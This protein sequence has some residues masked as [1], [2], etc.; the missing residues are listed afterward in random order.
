MAG[1]G[2]YAA[3]WAQSYSGGSGCA[4]NGNLAEIEGNID[5]YVKTGA[6]WIYVN[7]P[8]PAPGQSTATSAASIAY[9]V[10]GMN[11][12]YS[13]IHSKHPGVMFGLTLGDDGG[14]PL[15]LAMLKAGLLEDFAS[16][17]EYNSCCNTTN[18]FI[19]QK[20][21]FPNVKTMLLA[22]STESLCQNAGAY[23]NTGFDVIAFW[24]LDNYGGWIGPR[25]DGS[26]L[27][28]AEALAANGPG[29]AK[30]L[31]LNAGSNITNGTWNTYTTN[32]TATVWDTQ[33]SGAANQITSCDWMVMS[34]SG[35]INGPND[36]S[37]K[38]TLPWS[39]RA[40]KPG[41]SSSVTVTVGAKGYCNVIGN[42][43]CLVFTRVHTASGG[44]GNVYY[45][46]YS[47]DF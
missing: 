20:A 28:N 33:G 13:Y 46:E 19:A 8:C 9:N 17:E 39:S 11:L 15:H 40:C 41:N 38:V 44:L 12:L 18:P 31:C 24:D 22:Y 36:P 37:V 34:G 23:V 14:A 10:K 1:L 7:E 4:G 42:N 29:Y 2:G 16:E 32:F 45:Q 26:W 43:T 3:Q 25:M 35:A 47:I 27:Q 6:T 5:A 21:A 30:T